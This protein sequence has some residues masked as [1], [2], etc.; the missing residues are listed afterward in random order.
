MRLVSYAYF[1]AFAVT[2]PLAS[3]LVVY[4]VYQLRVYLFEYMAE[5]ATERFR[6]KPASELYEKVNAI[7]R[8][9]AKSSSM[10]MSQ[11]SKTVVA[12]QVHE[13]VRHRHTAQPS[14][15]GPGED[16][17][18]GGVRLRESLLSISGRDGPNLN[19]AA[20]EAFEVEHERGNAQ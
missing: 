1:L 7:M 8:Q 18:A 10:S 14:V 15:L 9:K 3:H 2:V 5:T 17:A 6:Q 16:G 12:T 13:Y 4:G 20:A 19:A 11:S